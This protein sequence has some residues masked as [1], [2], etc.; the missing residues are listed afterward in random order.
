[1]IQNFSLRVSTIIDHAARFHPNRPVIGRDLDGRIINSTRAKVLREA[2]QLASALRRLAVKKG[3][4]IGVMA[5]NTVRQLSVWCGIPGAGGVQRY[6][7][8]K[9]DAV[10]ADGWLGTGDVATIDPNGYVRITDRSKDM[11]KSGGEW[12]SSIE[13]ENCAVAHADIAEAAAVAVPHPK[14]NER[15]VL[16]PVALPG[17]SP[18]KAEIISLLE[19]R[20]A[21]WQLPDDILFVGELPHTAT[22]KIS[23]LELRQ[24]LSDQGYQLPNKG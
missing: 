16:R 18:D 3:D 6:L 13:M 8:Q 12:I 22:G 21:K 2:K 20:F 4:V 10:N 15:P 5:W 11:I 14:R 17:A 24:G 7:K 9:E 23:K 19:K 1:M